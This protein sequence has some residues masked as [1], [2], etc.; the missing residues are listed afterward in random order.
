MSPPKGL[1]LSPL[2]P[3]SDLNRNNQM[4]PRS[5]GTVSD[6]EIKAFHGVQAG[7]TG[8]PSQIRS[9]SIDG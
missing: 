8:N 7:Q 2:P 3:S 4:S 1:L 6:N 9:C 5:R